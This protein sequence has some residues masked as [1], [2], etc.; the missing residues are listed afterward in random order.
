MPYKCCAPGCTGNYDN[1]P[2]VQMFNFPVDDELRKQWI[3]AIPRKDF[4]PSK[5]TRICIL[6]FSEADLITDITEQDSRNGTMVTIKLNKPRLKATALPCNF[7]NCQKYFSKSSFRRKTRDEKLLQIEQNNLATAIEQSKNEYLKHENSVRFANIDEFTEKPLTLP[8]GWFKII[9]LE[10]VTFFRLIN[11]PGPTITYAFTLNSNLQ[12]ETFLFGHKISLAINN[13]KTPFNT[14]N[15]NEIKDVLE[16][17]NGMNINKNSDEPNKQKLILNHMSEILNNF[18]SETSD[19]S[20]QYFPFLSE[21]MTLQ[22]T[23]KERYRYSANTM[24]LSSLIY[25][26]S[27]HA[28]TFL[29]SSNVL[30]LPHPQTIKTVCNSYLSDP[31]VEERQLFLKYAQNQFKFLNENENNMILLFDEIHIKPFLDYKA[32]N[33]VGIANNNTSLATTAFVFMIISVNS[34]FKEVVHIS[35]V[36][37]IN[38][39]SLFIFIKSIILKLEQI[40]YKIFCVISDNNALNSKAMNNFSKHNKLSIVYPHPADNSRPLF[41]LFDSVHILKCIRNNWLNSKPN[42]IMQYPNFDSGEE[43]IASFNALKKIHELEHDKLLKFGYSLNLKALY[44]TNLERQ[45]VKLALN[46]FNESTMQALLQFGSNIDYSKSTADFI[47][48]VLTWWKII[49]VKTPLKGQ[50]LR[51]IFQEPIVKGHL[52]DDL[53]IKFL[54]NLLNWLDMWKSSSALNKLTTQTHTAWSHTVYGILQII[55]YCFNELNLN[56]ILL[57]KFQTDPLEERFGKYRQLAGG[58]YHISLR[59]LYESEKRLRIQSV[60]TLQ[61]RIFGTINIDSFSDNLH[62]SEVQSDEDFSP[63]IEITSQDFEDIKHLMPVITYLGGYCSYIATK[64]LKCEYCKLNLVS[65]E[66]LLVEDS[67]NLIKNLSRGGLSYPKETVSH[68]VM[69]EYI[70]FTKLLKHHE[71]QFLIILNKHLFLCELVLKYITR[72]NHLQNFVGCE[73]HSEKDIACLIIKCTSNTLL[74]NYCKKNNDQL[75]SSC[76]S[77]KLQTLMRQ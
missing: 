70:I 14:N 39:E 52:E 7:P 23:C 21:Q 76:K 1:G 53:K 19:E 35:P 8:P 41:Y 9:E 32:G 58:Q 62:I 50:R 71:E 46:V 25:T 68:L 30:I 64:K 16:V 47:R 59:Q 29:R 72:E 31:I 5:H 55:S 48:I 15:L 3:S 75:K 49:N 45:N 18:A 4:K 65:S 73:N 22:T 28:Y 51:D 60:L 17:L 66:D 2:K 26:I 63:E 67:Y 57:G 37:K 38:H 24:I 36:S 43:N 12:V 61:S 10:K 11:N 77:R 69:L 20:I 13:N 34:K 54:R 74:N 42:Q 27:P 6:H 40:G 33:I 56:Y 44:P